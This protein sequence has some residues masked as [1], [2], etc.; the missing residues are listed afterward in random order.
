MKP[1]AIKTTRNFVMKLFA[2]VFI[3]ILIGGCNDDYF[4]PEWEPQ[5]P[6]SVSM[7]PADADFEKFKIS[8]LS[9]P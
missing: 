4:F 5:E 8:F 6:T 2:L 1:H 7:R 3:L 9:H